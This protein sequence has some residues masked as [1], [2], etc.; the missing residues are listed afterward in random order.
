VTARRD[1]FIAEVTAGLKGDPE[2]RR[3]VSAEI[4]SH[5]DAAVEESRAQ[6]RTDE[7]S[8]DD[9]VKAFGSPMALAGDLAQ[10]NRGRMRLRGLVRLAMGAIVVP[11]AIA[12]AAWMAVRTVEKV[13]IASAMLQV[14]TLPNSIPAIMPMSYE[15]AEERI[16]SRWHLDQRER[17]IVFGDHTKPTRSEQQRALC[18]L[19]PSNRMF[20]ANYIR[21]R[22]QDSYTNAVAVIGELRAGEQL[23]PDN[24]WYN[25]LA[26][27]AMMQQA[28]KWDRKGEGTN[29][30]MRLTIL[31]TNLLEEAMAEFQR[32]VDKPFCK[33]YES[34]LMAL[35]RSLMPKDGGIDDEL[36]K[37][38]M[39]A[40]VLLPHLSLYRDM[41]RVSTEYAAT[42]MAQ[43]RT[44]EAVAVL[45]RLMPFAEDQV[46][47]SWC[48]IEILV[49]GAVVG[50]VEKQAVPMLERAGLH[51]ESE[52][53]RL[54][55]EAANAP[56]KAWRDTVKNQDVSKLQGKAGILTG[57]LVQ[58]IG[59]E[60]LADSDFAPGR[61]RD[62]VM[63]EQ[64]A[65][66]FLIALFA[67]SLLLHGILALRWWRGNGA[68]SAS[69]LVL[70]DGRQALWIVSVSVVLPLLV[71]LVYTRWSGLA[72][73]ENAIVLNFWRHVLEVF[74]LGWTI[75]V[76]ATWM[77]QRF[78]KRRCLALGVPVP[79]KRVAIAWFAVWR[80]DYGV[81]L[82]TVAR[83]LIPTFAVAILLLGGVVQ[84]WLAREEVRSIRADTLLRQDDNIGGFTSVE[85]RSVN[86]LKAAMLRR[87]P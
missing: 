10:A 81:Y 28:G 58:A 80:S 57:M 17:V 85:T 56:F 7:E 30:S 34:D 18:E 38:G 2:L 75:L 70:P 53:M 71:F 61:Y 4:G 74:A 52:A 59:A 6:G 43:G 32:G 36:L 87:A 54:R 45:G 27:G 69:F 25:Y 51:K 29:K 50:I 8:L 19:E 55:V 48:L 47:D 22:M 33:T 73:R 84:P 62:Y 63:L 31:D 20:Y 67:V 65:V 83:S 39:T 3:D 77:T 14:F 46:R 1:Q 13:S 16:A 24:A 68:G 37:I 60:G 12:L 66:M 64:S 23:D 44:N 9:A 78:V 40:G 86:R 11:A 82:G 72:G 49:A 35:R 76:A 42:L 15:K 21:H 5:L 41:A 26:A 79:R